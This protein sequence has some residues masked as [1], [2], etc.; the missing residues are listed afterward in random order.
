MGARKTG[1][2]VCGVQSSQTD[3][4]TEETRTRWRHYI[5]KTQGVV[6]DSSCTNRKYSHLG[7]SGSH[8]LRVVASVGELDDE[9]A[10]G[11]TFGYHF[12]ANLILE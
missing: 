5:G 7:A 10:S 9:D 12:A 1:T 8:R 4:D 11:S 6:G 2:P 3:Q